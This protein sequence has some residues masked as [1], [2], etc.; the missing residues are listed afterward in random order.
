MEAES[1]QLLVFKL[2]FAKERLDLL[3]WMLDIGSSTVSDII[4]IGDS[5]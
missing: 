2:N 1:F 5:I 4:V 3:P